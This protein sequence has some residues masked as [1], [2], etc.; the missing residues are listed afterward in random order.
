MSTETDLSALTVGE[1]VQFFV[2]TIQFRKTI[3]HVG[4]SNRLIDQIWDAL[5]DALKARDPALNCLRGLLGHPDREVRY[6]TLLSR[7]KNDRPCRLQASPGRFG[8]G[9]NDDV[10]L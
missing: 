3:K 4:R 7:F 8:R 9:L 10:G 5:S 1:L 2:D 6:S